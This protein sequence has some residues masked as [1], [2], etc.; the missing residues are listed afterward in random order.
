MKSSLQ[1]IEDRLD[2]IE[3]R[4]NDLLEDLRLQLAQDHISNSV[5]NSAKD[6][7]QVNN[8]P[9]GSNLMRTRDSRPQ[10]S[11]KATNSSTKTKKGRQNF[12]KVSE[13]ENVISNL[14]DLK[15]Y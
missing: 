14:I 2:Y 6:S 15:G 7:L 11:S 1:S 12:F 4:Q 8:G 5:Q 13:V 9:S 10:V 3:A